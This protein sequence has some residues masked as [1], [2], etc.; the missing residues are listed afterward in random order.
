MAD[1][2]KGERG[3]LTR[4]PDEAIHRFAHEA[5]GLAAAKH[6]EKI[7]WAYESMFWDDTAKQAL[8][9]FAGSPTKGENREVFQFQFKRCEERGT[10][11]V[12]VRMLFYEGF[13][14]FAIG[15][16]SFNISAP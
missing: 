7:T 4:L 11:V 14:V 13:E 8:A 5:A 15:A 2:R 10:A 12:G 6:I 9:A 3:R 16:D 1:D